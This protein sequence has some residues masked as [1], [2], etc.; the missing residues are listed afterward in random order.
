VRLELAKLIRDGAPSKRAG[1]SLFAAAD[2]GGDQTI[3]Q[4]TDGLALVYYDN[5]LGYYRSQHGQNT[6]QG[7][8]DALH[9]YAN[10]RANLA[11]GLTAT[12][13]SGGLLT[14]AVINQLA[15]AAGL[16]QEF[17]DSSAAVAP[18][19]PSVDVWN[20][21]AASVSKGVK[22][23]GQAATAATGAIGTGIGAVEKQAS[24]DLASVGKAAGSALTAAESAV[25]N[26]AQDLANGV[27]GAEALVK[28]LVG[29]MSPQALEAFVQKDLANLQAAFDKILGQKVAAADAPKGS[30]I[31]SGSNAIDFSKLPIPRTGL[32]AQLFPAQYR[33]QTIQWSDARHNAGSILFYLAALSLVDSLHLVRLFEQAMGD[34]FTKI[35]NVLGI[36]GAD[37]RERTHTFGVDPASATGAAVADTGGIGGSISTIIPVIIAVLTAAAGIVKALQGPPTMAGPAA[38]PARAPS[39]G[40]PG[41]PGG[42][43]M[44]PGMM[45]GPNGLIPLPPGMMLGPNGPVPI[46][47]SPKAAVGH[48]NPIVTYVVIG[49]FIATAAFLLF[50]EDEP[51]TKKKA[52]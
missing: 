30:S 8:L 12:A 4:R 45:L 9:Q 1:A 23:V 37:A 11:T 51:A 40:L 26:A 32:V 42:P 50:W 25:K 2:F 29:G 33:G 16:P 15:A 48:S 19:T 21:I 20:Q 44:P 13:S 28:Q 5:A 52:A 10:N 22:A 49:L 24:Q 36:K 14:G 6:P 27:A 18:A 39:T 31:T 46:P 43:P 7:V 41:Q 38:G 35:K 47:S 3:Q 34:V 17:V